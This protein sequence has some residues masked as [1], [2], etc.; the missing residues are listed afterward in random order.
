[1]SKEGFILIIYN[2]ISTKDIDANKFNKVLI[3]NGF[4]KMNSHIYYRYYKNISLSVYTVKKIVN[5]V[6]NNVDIKIIQLSI[7]QFINMDKYSLNN[8]NISKFTNNIVIY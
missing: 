3:G 1:M 8:E 7:K 4:V 5:K 2:I 6:E